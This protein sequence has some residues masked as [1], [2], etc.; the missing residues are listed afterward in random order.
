LPSFNRV[1]VIRATA[2]FFVP[3]F[4]EKRLGKINPIVNSEVERQL[5]VNDLL[6]N[7]RL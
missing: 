5:F 1:G 4:W 6:D 7:R 2:T 3:V